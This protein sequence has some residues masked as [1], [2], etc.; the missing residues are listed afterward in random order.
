MLCRVRMMPEFQVSWLNAINQSINFIEGKLWTPIAHNQ[1]DTAF[2][3][4][5]Q[6]QATE[7][8]LLILLVPHSLQES[9]GSLFCNGKL[10]YHI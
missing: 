5:N 8:Y 3:T 9:S 1:I 6:L 4:I 7:H 2:Q 10:L